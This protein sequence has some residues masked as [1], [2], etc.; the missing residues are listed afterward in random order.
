MWINKFML[1]IFAEKESF[2]CNK[3]KRIELTEKDGKN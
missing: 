1:S 2:T 3:K